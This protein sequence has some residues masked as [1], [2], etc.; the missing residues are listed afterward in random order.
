M[1]VAKAAA[2]KV[3]QAALRANKKAAARLKNPQA[4]SGFAYTTDEEDSSPAQRSTI[5]EDNR[6]R[7][8][9]FQQALVKRSDRKQHLLTHSQPLPTEDGDLT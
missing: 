7:Q 9:Q 5:P 8:Q 2:D 1:S 4:G 6:P 3:I